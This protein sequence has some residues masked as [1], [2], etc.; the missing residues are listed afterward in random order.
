[1]TDYEKIIAQG[2]YDSSK[3]GHAL[4]ASYALTDL[5]YTLS[6]EEIGKMSEDQVT[7]AAMN[8]VEEG[9]AQLDLPD[10]P[11]NIRDDRFSHAPA[12]VDVEIDDVQFDSVEFGMI[13][14]TVELHETDEGFAERLQ[15][16]K[17][18]AANVAAE[19][20]S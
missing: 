11:W 13:E 20:N 4:N 18:A 5:L 9:T 12:V 17:A 2:P 8:W 10:I 19:S 14:L 15:S 6:A 7:E 3:A 16:E 1:M